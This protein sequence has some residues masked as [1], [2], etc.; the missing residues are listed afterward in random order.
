MYGAG[1]FGYNQGTI[2]NVKVVNANVDVLVTTAN[3][4]GF[5]Y[6]EF[7]FYS[8]IICSMNY[9]HIENCF[10]Q[11]TLKVSTNLPAKNFEN[12]GDGNWFVNAEMG[13]ISWNRGTVKECS[14]E[15]GISLVCPSITPYM[16]VLLGKVVP[17]TENITSISAQTLEELYA[18]GYIRY[19]QSNGYYKYQEAKWH[20]IVSILPPMENREGYSFV[21]WSLSEG[22]E[23]SYRV[24]DEVFIPSDQKSLTLYPVWESSTNKTLL[25]S[26]RGE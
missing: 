14:A 23:V 13:G 25:D 16:S 18:V 26:N 20:A 19:K 11:G 15:V 21:G 8:G 10:A 24:G 17:D 22:G 6:N 1:L 5:S 3:P 12:R 4:A 2:R 7:D 9:G